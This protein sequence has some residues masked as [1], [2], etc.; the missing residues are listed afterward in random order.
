MLRGAE[1]CKAAVMQCGRLPALHRAS[2]K[3]LAHVVQRRKPM[4]HA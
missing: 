3:A 4:E 1:P 2:G